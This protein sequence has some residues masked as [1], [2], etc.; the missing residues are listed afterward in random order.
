[1]ARVKAARR[2]LFP[3]RPN[4]LETNP[5]G[6]ALP[7]EYL[8]PA[9]AAV[10]GSLLARNRGT[11]VLDALRGGG[12]GL[13]LGAG[14]VLAYL[15]ARKAGADPGGATLAGAGGGVAG[16]LG[17]AAL[18]KAL[19]VD[20]PARGREAAPVPYPDDMREAFGKASAALPALLEAKAESDRKNYARKHMI[21][22]RLIREAPADFVVDSAAGGVVGVTHRPTGFRVHLP[23]RVLPPEL[24][25]PPAA[26]KAAAAAALSGWGHVPAA[27]AEIAAA[28]GPAVA[29]LRAARPDRPPLWWVDAAS[30]EPA[31][32]P[33][34]PAGFGKR[35][36]V[37]VKEA[38]GGLLPLW[39]VLHM[40]PSR[41]ADLYGGPTPLAATLAGGALG[42]GAGY[43]AGYLAEQV[44][45][46]G[47]VEPGHLRR[48]GMILGGLAGAAPGV[49]AG[50]VNYRLARDEGR[51]GLAG[52]V[53]P[54][55]WMGYR[56][57]PADPTDVTAAEAAARAEAARAAMLKAGAFVREAA[58][59][60]AA[61]LPG[62]PP[63]AVVKAAEAAG[64]LFMPD[65]PVD[66]FSRAVWEDPL[67]PVAVR[68]ATVGLVDGAARAAGARLVSP[69]DVG[70]V[71]AG[72]GSGLASGMLVGKVLGALA[73][74]TPAA[75]KVVR[76]T[77]M[78]AG[79]L[80]N[81]VPKAFGM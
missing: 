4:P 51:P 53:E 74:L 43:G 13:G 79:A 41:L 33:A 6:I 73:G 57:D 44:F 18:L 3:G 60:L 66:S 75:Q 26:E 78:W 30:G 63:A 32:D 62:G 11:P 31:W 37:P 1:M 77:G 16:L 23:R 15:L 5:E 65:I 81:V 48:Q 69:F 50:S 35:A 45:G 49:Y 42:A 10:G 38:A 20:R 67:T 54:N 34:P 68:A 25:A 58:E 12:K 27:A 29:A 24:A 70:R 61:V 47:V 39:Q 64:A 2:G 14:A 59:D 71:V 17:A 22:R 55:R 80:T 8:V 7:G 28:A 36:W 76:Q 19:R 56:D 72:M 9:A 21:L 40:A 52:L 46:P